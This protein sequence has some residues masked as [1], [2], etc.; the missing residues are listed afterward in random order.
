MSAVEVTGRLIC[1]SVEEMSIV[2]QHLP[3]HI[4][5]T[6]AEPGCERF[7]VKLTSHPFVFAVSERFVDQAA[8]A[9]HQARTA[10]S[11]WGRATASVKRE[12]EVRLVD[13]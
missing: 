13:D 6:R 1:S 2:T 5:L 8:Y 7:E 12:V 4:Q 11:E 10:M 9:A 3:R